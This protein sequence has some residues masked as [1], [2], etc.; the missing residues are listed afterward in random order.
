[1]G[2][3]A[4]AWPLAFVMIGII[5]VATLILAVLLLV[6]HLRGKDRQTTTPA[7]SAEP[8][9]PNQSPLA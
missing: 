1:M 5:V 4:W 2:I 8:Q 9:S 7:P 3:S 6:N